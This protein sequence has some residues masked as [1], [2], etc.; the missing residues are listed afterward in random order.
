MLQV[1]SHLLSLRV[2]I[3]KGMVHKINFDDIRQYNDS[4]V[5]HYIRLLLKDENFQHILQFIFNDQVKIEEI[6]LMLNQINTVKDLQHELSSKFT[7]W[8]KMAATRHFAQNNGQ[9][10]ADS[11]TNY[12]IKIQIRYQF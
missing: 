12:E 11:S 5:N 1:R 9:Q 3:E 6:K 7:L 2:K 4:E 10:I 8:L